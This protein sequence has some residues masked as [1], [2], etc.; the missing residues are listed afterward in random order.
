MHGWWPL[1]STARGK[2]LRWVGS[3]VADARVTLV[4]ETTGETLDSWPKAR[5]GVV[6]GSP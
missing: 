3:G 5:P 1:E 4:D 2:F 6:G